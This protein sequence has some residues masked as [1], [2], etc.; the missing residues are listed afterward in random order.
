MASVLEQI[1]ETEREPKRL[2]LTEDSSPSEATAASSNV[3]S[4]EEPLFEQRVGITEYICP[5]WTGFKAMIKNRCEDFLVN[6]I[7][8]DGKL[9]ESPEVSPVHVSGLY[10]DEAKKVLEEMK[11]EPIDD[12]TER[13]NRAFE[14]LANLMGDEHAATLK[15]H[16]EIKDEE[17]QWQ[18]SA[19]Q[20]KAEEGSEASTEAPRLTKEMAKDLLQKAQAGRTLVLGHEFSKDARFKIYRVVGMYLYDRVEVVRE[21]Q[22]T[23][24]VRISVDHVWQVARSF[25]KLAP[26]TGMGDA[27]TRKGWQH[28]DFVL[29]KMNMET[30]AVL[31]TLARRLRTSPNAFRVAGNKDK[32]AVTVQ[33]VTAD[34]ISHTQLL[35]K[36]KDL[37]GV[38][39]NNFEYYGKGRR[40]VGL[41]DLWGNRFCV[42][43]RN[44]DEISAEE[45]QPVVER[46]RQTGFINYFGMQRFG[47]HGVKTH[48]IGLALIRQD[49]VRA[50]DLIMDP[51]ED[52]DPRLVRM[53]QLWK[54]GDVDGALAAAPKYGSAVAELAIL[55]YLARNK[56][57]VDMRAALS[58]IPQ[59][60]LSLYMHAY[61]SFVFNQAASMRIRT[62]GSSGPVIGDLVISPS[63]KGGVDYV[64]ADNISKYSIHDVAVPVVGHASMLPRNEVGRFIRTH[65]QEAG[66]SQDALRKHPIRACILPGAY[67]AVVEKPCNLV[68]D[69]MAYD[70][71]KAPLGA[72]DAAAHTEGKYRALRL[73]F[74]L[75]KSTYATML[76]R[77]I[78]RGETSAEV[79]S[80]LVHPGEPEKEDQSRAAEA[81]DAPSTDHPNSLE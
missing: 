13:F 1:D 36:A 53:R 64:T 17:I 68:C 63:A 55:E 41:G 69:L 35:E 45:L 38:R 14:H 5:G 9:V 16:L 66:I 4:N 58:A 48:E 26:S 56:D 81:Q 25:P 71:P 54:Q 7:T 72:C 2:R 76:I 15:R 34:R 49:F 74:D 27:A 24:Y 43:L 31:S 37:Q 10:R 11:L 78:T 8:A 52:D 46:L 19:A 67:R 77:E 51:R 29:Q 30:M 62:Y 59:R 39:L 70:D 42:V 20:N 21:E 75:T 23:K 65:L 73:R 3:D 40:P 60:S 33:R 80:R 32:R 47:T 79:Q 22:V 44:V 6:E 50:V 12:P 18:Q 57:R 28:C 61:Q